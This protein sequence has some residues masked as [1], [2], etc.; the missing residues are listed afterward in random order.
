MATASIPLTQGYTAVVDDADAQLVLRHKWQV[1]IEQHTAYAQ[2]TFRQAGRLRCVSMHRFILNAGPSDL[3]DHADG[4]GLNNT[5][6]NLRLA[7]QAQNAW[8]R[9]MRSDNS[10]GFKGVHWNKG[11]SR[12][13]ASIQRGSRKITIGYFLNAEDAARAYDAKAKALFGEFAHV[14]F[15]EGAS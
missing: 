8:N 9:S 6:S 1:R 2:T 13:V 3:V 4:N 10:S 11:R 7:T 14:N 12:W 5:R 15:L